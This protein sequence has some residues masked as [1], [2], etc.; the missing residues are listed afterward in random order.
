LQELNKALKAENDLLMKTV[1][2]Q[3]ETI[4]AYKSKE[5]ASDVK[6]SKPEI[7]A[8]PVTVDGKEYNFNVAVFVLPGYG[9][10]TAEEASTSEEILKAIIAIPGQGILKELV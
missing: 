9:K 8:K 5:I 3:S 7:P 2:E 6:I 10:M 4:L 1:Q